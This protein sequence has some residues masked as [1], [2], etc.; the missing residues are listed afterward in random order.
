MGTLTEKSSRDT[1]TTTKTKEKTHVVYHC[2][3]RPFALYH[4]VIC[5]VCGGGKKS[6]KYVL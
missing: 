5:F 6:N 1:R 2:L 3:I 4:S